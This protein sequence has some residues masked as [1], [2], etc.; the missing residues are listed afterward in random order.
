MNQSSTDRF[1]RILIGGVLLIIVSYLP[2]NIYLTWVLV[3]LGI[4][5]MVT[6]LTGFCP[7]YSLLKTGTKK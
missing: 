7:A 6:G 4:F 3:L 1:L 2:L 5:L